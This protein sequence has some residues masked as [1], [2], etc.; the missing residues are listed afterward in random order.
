MI[1]L[2]W[3]RFYPAETL[4]D[5]HFQGWNC[6]E[7]GAW[8][9][10]ILLAWKDGSIP[11]DE[12]SLARV[13][14]L[15]HSDFRRI[16]SAIGSRFVESPDI[17]GRLTS[18]RL[19]AER[20]KALATHA[21]RSRAGAEAIKARWEKEKAK[22]TKRIRLVQPANTEPIRSDTG[23]GTGT[24]AASYEAASPAAGAAPAAWERLRDALS[25]RMAVPRDW[26]RL[27]RPE[28]AEAT[29]GMLDA[30]VERLG[31]ARAVEVAAEAASRAKSKPRYLRYFVG[32]LQ[33]ASRNTAPQDA[34]QGESPQAPGSAA[35]PE[36]TPEQEAEWAAQAK[37]E[38]EAKRLGGR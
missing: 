27:S 9:S 26:M 10:L 6:E 13:L 37:A 28:D 33:D 1:G 19:E 2:S 16:W 15:S 20:E 35:W 3:L 24:E 31:L 5:E 17:P 7:R 32:P 38:L 12:P 23:S 34:W 8:F 25:D 21:K 11:A 14:H 4:S 29:R 22:H 18:P 30:E 36:P